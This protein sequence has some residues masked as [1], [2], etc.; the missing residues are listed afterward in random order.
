M[1][2]CKYLYYKYNVFD[3]CIYIYIIERRVCRNCLFCPRGMCLVR[4]RITPAR[5]YALHAAWPGVSRL[6]L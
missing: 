3:I 6:Q 5:D 1:M 2:K 4:S